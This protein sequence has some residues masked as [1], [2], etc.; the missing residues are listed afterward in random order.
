MAL[1]IRP[2]RP[3]D[4]SAIRAVTAAAFRGAPVS[5]PPMDDAGGPGEAPL[6]E[7]LRAIAASDPSWGDFFQIRLLAAYDGA[8]GTFRYAAPFARSD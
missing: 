7:W 5:A 3:E 2:E 6:I 8:R 4:F 1:V